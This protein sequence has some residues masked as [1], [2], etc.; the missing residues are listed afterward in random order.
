MQ[1]LLD[2]HIIECERLET[3]RFYSNESHSTLK[4]FR[5]VSKQ[6]I[7]NY[8]V[9]WSLYTDISQRLSLKL[10]SIEVNLLGFGKLQ[11]KSCEKKN[12]SSLV[13]TP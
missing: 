10:K 11:K 5:F 8:S 2:N 12:I 1:L 7:K 13:E 3:R 9:Q 6:F 4:F